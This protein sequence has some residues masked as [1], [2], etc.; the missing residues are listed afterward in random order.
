[1]NRKNL[2]FFLLLTTSM[3]LGFTAQPRS[4][5]A[6][7][8]EQSDLPLL[9]LVGSSS[10]DS[11]PNSMIIRCEGFHCGRYH[12][13]VYWGFDNRIY[14]LDARSLAPTGGP[15]QTSSGMPTIWSHRYLFYDRH[16]QQI[17]AVDKYDEGTFPNGWSRLVARI[18]RSSCS[19]LP[20]PR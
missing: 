16:Y 7:L 3:L 18:I 11:K 19:S 9:E 12:E 17:Y 2:A 13:L 14:F 4:K 20:L 8:L 5:A 1:M 6:A 15:L 10:V